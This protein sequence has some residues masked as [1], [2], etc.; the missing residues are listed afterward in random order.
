MTARR[1]ATA[2]KRAR[3]SV[4]GVRAGAGSGSGWVA[5][6][7]GLIVTALRVVGYAAH[8]AVRAGEGPELPAKVVFADTHLDVAFLM[9][10]AA[11]ALPPLELGDAAAARTGD[12]VFAIGHPPGRALS[13]SAR[14]LAATGLVVRGT[15]HLQTD[16]ALGPGLSGGPLLDR[17]G[18]A[19]AV[20]VE[21]PDGVG[22]ALPVGEIA[23]ALWSLAGPPEEVAKAGPTYRCLACDA[24]YEPER[25]RCRNCGTRVAY[26]GASAPS[27]R[28]ARGER[29]AARLLQALGFVPHQPRVGPGEWR[30]SAEGEEVRARLGEGGAEVGFSTRLV[31]LPPANHEG[32]YRFLLAANDRTTGGMRLGI[33]GA[34]V[35]LERGCDLAFLGDGD[36]SPVL[37]DLTGLASRLRAVLQEAF[38]A[39]PAPIEDEGHD[40]QAA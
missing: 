10:E 3:A 4:V 39:P 18:R 2:F 32:F 13:V 30:V 9:P 33:D 21:G 22:L 15:P 37:R 20:C 35:T 16:A 24:A 14:V 8:A 17:G 31:G 5:L 38:S 27:P 11:L 28:H 23:D 6:E 34:S 12:R 19:I 1:A 36:A 26:L 25:E 7:N 29:A 40:G